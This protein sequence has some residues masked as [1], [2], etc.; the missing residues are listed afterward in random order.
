MDQALDWLIE[1][2][3][4]DSAQQARFQA[5]LRADPAH[6]EAFAQAEAIW[7]GQ[8]IRDTANALGA[9]TSRRQRLRAWIRP[10]VAA[11]V[12]LGIGY[13]IDLPLRLQADHLTVAGERQRLQLADGSSV[14]LNTRSAFSSQ[15]DSQHREARL[16][17]GEAFLDVPEARGLPLEIAAGPL[18]VSTQGSALSL[19][20]LDG[21]ARVQVQRGAADIHAASGGARLRLAAGD[22]V[23]LGP[24][25]LGQRQR[26]DPARDL[27]W[28]QGRLVFDNCP[29]GQVLD[30]LRRYYPGLIVTAS[31][32]LAKVNVT[33]NYRLDD[34]LDVVRSLAQVTSASLHELPRLLIL[35]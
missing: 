15:I 16:Y 8:V 2:E 20:Y 25:G 5:W 32:T 17:E 18:R 33:G 23:S 22:S 3:S 4:A 6:A 28:V 1:L 12:L 31:P 11:A 29:L 30:E 24:D 7:N 10:M 9:R 19:R 35:N 13:G 27:A 21:Q 34:P 26:L 14:L